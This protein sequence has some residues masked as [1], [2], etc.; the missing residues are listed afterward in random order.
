MFLT[1]CSVQRHSRRRSRQIGDPEATNQN[2]YLFT[3][4]S[5][6]RATKH[7]GATRIP[8]RQMDIKRADAFFHYI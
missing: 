7:F 3:E 5:G 1:F 4:R 2:Q 8:V 6:D